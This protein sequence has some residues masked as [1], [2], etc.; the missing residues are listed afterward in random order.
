[1]GA[2]EPITSDDPREKGNEL[3]EKPPWEKDL[4]S[5][6]FVSESLLVFLLTASLYF[7]RYEYQERRRGLGA[8]VAGDRTPELQG[9]PRR[10]LSE[11]D[12]LHWR[13]VPL[14]PL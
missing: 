7:P 10:A 4:S 12:L 6:Y 1:M 3:E 9:V 8:Y 14:R 2:V 13:L 11:Q 5:D